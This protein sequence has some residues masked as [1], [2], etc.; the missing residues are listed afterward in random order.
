MHQ[1]H[2]RLLHA[3]LLLR[4]LYLAHQS[5]LGW[6][7]AAAAGALLLLLCRVGRHLLQSAAPIGLLQAR[8]P[9]L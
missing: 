4:L 2:L 3:P 8:C 5:L 6:H 7:S 9:P 1:S